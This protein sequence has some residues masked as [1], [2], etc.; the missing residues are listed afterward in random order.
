MSSLVFRLT[1]MFWKYHSGTVSH[2]DTLL[3]KE[4]VTLESNDLGVTLALARSH[5]KTG[6]RT[7]E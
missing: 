5:R 3:D 7:A 6:I 2:V 1:D 4:G